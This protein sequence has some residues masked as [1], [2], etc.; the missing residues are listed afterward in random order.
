MCVYD[1]TEKEWERKRSDHVV[2]SLHYRLLLFAND[3]SASR[4]REREREI[5]RLDLRVAVQRL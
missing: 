1:E 3:R 2:V 4:E 5:V